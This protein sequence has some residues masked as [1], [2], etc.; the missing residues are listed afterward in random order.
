MSVSMSGP[1]YFVLFWYVRKITTN[2]LTLLP[3]TKS[4]R[5]LEGSLT[6][7]DMDNIDSCFLEAVLVIECLV[8]PQTVTMK[9]A[10]FLTGNK[11]EVISALNAEDSARNITNFTPKMR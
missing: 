10:V 7:R 5:D 6:V 11:M 2:F 9:S 1:I 3:S 8:K 4:L